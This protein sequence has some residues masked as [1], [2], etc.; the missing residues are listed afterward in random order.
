MIKSKKSL[1]FVIPCRNEQKTIGQVLTKINRLCEHDFKDR[2][3]QVIVCDNG[4]TDHSVE[5]CREHGAKVVR[6]DRQGYGSALL[7]GIEEA[8]GDIVV[9][10]DADNTYDFLETP[11]LVEKLQE[12]YDLIIGSRL[13][14][15]IHKGAM[16]FLHRYLGT[17]VL[18]F[19]LN[20]LYAG[21]GNKIT[22]CNSGFRCFLRE[23]FLSW[24]VMSEGM[25][26]ASEMLGKALK[27]NARISHVPV[28]LYPD[29]AGRAPHLKRW[30]D[31][32]RHLL[33]IFS[34]LGILLGLIFGPVQIGFAVILGLHT[35]MFGLFGGVFGI[36][37]WS[38]GLFLAVK[39]KSNVR[40]YQYLIE[41]PEDKLFWYS[42]ILISVS[43]A[44]FLVI[45]VHW[46]LRGFRDIYVEKQTLAL[47]AFAVD[48]T[49]L[50]SNVVTAHL[51]KRS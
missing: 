34:S 35:M 40:I 16:P 1:S 3:T 18:N 51:L 41:L 31:G 22:D 10:A 46:S 15:D 5:I 20:M 27:S 13:Q 17:P 26:F 45:F 37:V 43:F 42:V 29:S 25:E 2:Q 44:L 33:Q 23:S 6:W 32:M 36:I 12:G 50:A 47:V 30:R 11:R 9:F 4:S 38:I 49:L 19:F 24:R 48:G 14:G 8:T 21:K 28:S 7:R 39:I